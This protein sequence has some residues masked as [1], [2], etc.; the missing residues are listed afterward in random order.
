MNTERAEDTEDTGEIPFHF[1]P[2]CPLRS[3]CPLW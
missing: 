2:L 3:P 1:V